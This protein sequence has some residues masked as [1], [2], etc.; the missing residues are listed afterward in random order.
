VNG[1][2]LGEVRLYYDTSLLALYSGDFPS[3]GDNMLTISDSSKLQLIGLANQ[4]NSYKA[5]FKIKTTSEAPSELVQ[6]AQLNNQSDNDNDGD[7]IPDDLDL[8]DDS[9]GILDTIDTSPTDYDGDGMNDNED[10][11]D[12][13]DG[14]L[15]SVEASDN[16][17]NT[18]I[19]DPFKPPEPIIQEVISF[20][21]EADYTYIEEGQA[22]VVIEE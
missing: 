10:E 8:D 16:N 22:T 11:D 3:S 4:W 15:D 5:I 18:N 9:D 20:S 2:E 21:A 13:G 17:P 19:Y 6:L 12:D 7:G 14:I 1:G